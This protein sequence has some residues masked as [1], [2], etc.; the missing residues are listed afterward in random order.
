MSSFWLFLVAPVAVVGAILFFTV[1][2]EQR[3]VQESVHQEQQRDRAE[4]DASFAKAWDG[5]ADP[6]LEARA[7]E[8]NTKLAE[9]EKR[10]AEAQAAAKAKQ[11]KDLAEFRAALD[12]AKQ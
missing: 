7:A 1:Y 9:A 2:G 6:Q 11:D 12:E 8:A 3:E 5:K 10:K 4:F